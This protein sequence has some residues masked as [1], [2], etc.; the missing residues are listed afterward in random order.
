MRDLFFF[1]TNLSFYLQPLLSD[2][3]DFLLL[4]FPLG[5]PLV[6]LDSALSILIEFLDIGLLRLEANFVLLGT[7]TRLSRFFLFCEYRHLLNS[8]FFESV[9]FFHPVDSILRFLCTHIVI[10]HFFDFSPNS[11]F[12][13][14][15]Q[16]HD[17]SS[18]LLS[19]LDFFPC[20]HLLLLEQRNTIGEKLCI[21]FN[22]EN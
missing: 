4:H 17:L 11:L 18:F 22:S 10:L 12:V 3:L 20:L 14:L 6:L 19:L 8:L 16:A 1:V 13:L 21:T 7:Y 15:L 9:L 5:H 2:L